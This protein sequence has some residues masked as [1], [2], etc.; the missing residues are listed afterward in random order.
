[1]RIVEGSG[2][3]LQMTGLIARLCAIGD[4]FKKP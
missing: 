2:T 1:M 3:F 4:K